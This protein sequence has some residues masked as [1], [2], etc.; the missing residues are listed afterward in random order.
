MDVTISKFILAAVTTKTGLVEGNFPIFVAES[1]EEQERMA[2][3]LG[4]VLEGVVHDM[5]NGVF[6]LVKH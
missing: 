4:R 1:Q 3:T 5:E 6:I 2:R